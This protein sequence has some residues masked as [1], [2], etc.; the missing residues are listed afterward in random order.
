[1]QP[2]QPLGD[3]DALGEPDV[4]QLQARGQVADAEIV[5]TPVWQYSSTVTKPRSTSTPASS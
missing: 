5:G 4:R 3:Q 1:V 2:G